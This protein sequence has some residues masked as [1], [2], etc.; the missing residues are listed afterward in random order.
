M[1]H[2]ISCDFIIF[3]F[4]FKFR[5]ITPN[6]KTLIKSRLFFFEKK[7]L[8]HLFC[9]F[10][11]ILRIWPHLPMSQFHN[12]PGNHLSIVLH[13]LLHSRVYTHHIRLLYHFPID[14]VIKSRSRQRNNYPQ[15]CH[16]RHGKTFLFHLLYY[17][18]IH[19][20]ILHHQAIFGLLCHL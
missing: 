13:I 12:L 3:P 2:Y 14:L 15:I 7:Y 17:F 1:F 10:Y 20:D 4:S 16:H 5:P 18:S 6:I 8:C 19:L 11:N 9:L